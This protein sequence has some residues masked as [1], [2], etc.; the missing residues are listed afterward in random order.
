MNTDNLSEGF[1]HDEE[2]IKVKKGRGRPKG[3]I[4]PKTIIAQKEYATRQLEKL[5]ARLGDLNY[6][7][8]LVGEKMDKFKAIIAA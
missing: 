4:D 6:Q 2:A 7:I 1:N 8:D 5:Q 3:T